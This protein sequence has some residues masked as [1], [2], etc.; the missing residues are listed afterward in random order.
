MMPPESEAMRLR[1][2]AQW[3]VDGR[4]AAAELE[5]F[6]WHRQPDR[7]SAVGVL[8]AA[9]LARRGNIN[10]A[11]RVLQR[12]DGQHDP[13]AARLLVCVLVAMDLTE[14]ASRLVHQLHQTYSHDADVERWLEIMEAPGVKDLPSHAEA[15]VRDLAIEL[16]RKP[17]VIP[18][19]VAAQKI[20]PR[21]EDLL[22]LRR[23]IELASRDWVDDETLMSDACLALAELALLA[24]DNDDARRWAHRG[25]RINRYNA[26]L[27]LVLANLPDDPAVGPSAANIL[28]GAL[29]ENPRYSDL[30]IALVRR[31]LVHGATDA[32]RA[33]VEDWIVQEPDNPHAQ[34]LIRE[35]A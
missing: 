2:L 17:A 1:R 4:L 25:L 7:P 30:R 15:Q 33:Q 16:Q 24:S 13:E 32:A 35:V 22:L 26:R 18:T 10:D 11:H 12:T 28:Q 14:T 21:H 29:A 8:L 9:L 20:T 34:R 19:L 23:S 5:L 6:E 3:C 31:L 27:A